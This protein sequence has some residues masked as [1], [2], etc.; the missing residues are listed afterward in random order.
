[1]PSCGT[2][3]HTFWTGGVW[4]GC[5]HQW[6]DTQCPACQVLSPHREWYHYPEADESKD[7]SLESVRAGA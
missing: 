3:W 7:R 2:V 5:G 4:P 1:V 6:R